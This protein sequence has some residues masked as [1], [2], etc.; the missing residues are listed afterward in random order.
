M[1]KITVILLMSL[2]S[3]LYADRVKSQDQQWENSLKPIGKSAKQLPLAL[4][5]KTD[6][7]IVVPASATTQ[8]QKAGEELRLWLGKMTGAQFGVIGDEQSPQKKEISVG[9]TNRLKKAKLK[10]AKKDLGDDGYGIAVKGKKLFLIGG[11]RRGPINA[12]VALLEEDLGCRWYTKSVNHIPNRPTLKFKPVSRTFIPQFEARNPRYRSTTD[13]LWSLRNRVNGS[14][15]PIPEEWG[16]AIDYSMWVHTFHV[17]VPPDKY[18]EEHPEYY[19]EREGKR[20][21][22]QLC[23]TNPKVVE[24]AAQTVLESLRKNP[25][26]ELVSVTPQDGGGYCQC[27]NCAALDKAQGSHAGSILQFVNQIAEKVE[28]EF[29]DVYVS[30][31]AY[32]WTAPLPKTIRPRK[33]VSIRFCTDT[34]MWERAFVSIADDEGPVPLDWPYWDLEEDPNKLSCKEMF[35]DWTKAHDRI[36]IWDYPINYSHYLAPQPNIEVIGKNIKFFAQHGVKAVMEQ[37]PLK[38]G[39][40]RDGMR[41]WV[42]AKLMWNPSLDTYALIQDF[43]Y[44]YYGKSAPAIAQYNQMLWEIGKDKELLAKGQRIRYAM[45]VEWLSNGFLERAKPMFDQAETLVEND[46]I[47][48]R[49]EL[50]RLPVIYVELSQLY[51]QFKDTNSIGDKEYYLELV[52]NFARIADEHNIKRSATGS[53]DKSIPNWIEKLRKA[54]EKPEPIEAK[55]MEI[56]FNLIAF[57]VSDVQ[58][59]V[60]FYR[61]VI[62]LEVKYMYGSYAEFKHKGIRFA[63]FEREVVPGWMGTTLGYPEGLNG[64][65]ELAIDLPYFADVDREFARTV[66]AGAKPVMQP[67]DTEWGQ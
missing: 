18:F 31:L 5:G 19:A 36:T 51:G 34:C 9:R 42:F 3:N 7:V 54:V 48:S 10:I 27:V 25:N 55:K 61:D 41:A 43:I 21:R 8:E 53:R 15:S 58:K 59:T 65:F 57:F 50:A 62:G 39:V 44:G 66:K 35:L 22:R 52:D 40:E 32:M 64:T 60:E 26:A 29:P 12:V 4:D 46:E 33:N 13:A 45:D 28:K 20:Q 6:Y 67:K 47:R 38:P 56:R 24:I 30:T 49:V 37:A 63:I 16:G 17:L 23:V 11:S 2:V 14:H 1:K